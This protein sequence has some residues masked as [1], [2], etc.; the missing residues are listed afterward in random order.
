MTHTHTKK[1]VK[2]KKKSVESELSNGHFRVTIF[3]SA[4][5]KE[6]DAT[7]KQIYELAKMIGEKGFDLITGGGPGIMN[8]ASAGHFKGD[9]RNRADSIGLKI[10]LPR[11]QK[12]SRHL[13]VEKIFTRFSSRLDNFM[14]LSN[15][16]VVT[17]GGIGTTL[18]LFYT[19]QLMQVGH[20]RPIPIILVGPM[21][22]ELV[23]W[24][25]R[26]LLRSKLIDK[27][28]LDHVFCVKTNVEAMKIIMKSYIMFKKDNKKYGAN[29]GQYK[30][31]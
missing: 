15:A 16:V 2:K 10:R 27:K 19:W 28:D 1:I 31:T 24:V 4:R 17:E 11:E 20:I 29:F 7:Y 21:W 22:R 25:R 5:I 3:G 9:R 26:Y 6:S 30:L 12:D 18:E 23:R 14:A 8:A 13:E